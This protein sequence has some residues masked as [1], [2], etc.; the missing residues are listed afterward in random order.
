MGGRLDGKGGG[1]SSSRRFGGDFRW[2][3]FAGFV[4]G[5][6]EPELLLEEVELITESC[7][8]WWVVDGGGCLDGAADLDDGGSM[9]AVIVSSPSSLESSSS[10]S[11]E[12][13]S[14]YLP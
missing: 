7:R 14:V 6:F 10:S 11:L 12:P 1:L 3:G 9:V 13:S 2:D 5:T 8:P 4:G